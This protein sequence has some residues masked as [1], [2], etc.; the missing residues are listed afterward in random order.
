MLNSYQFL[1]DKKKDSKAFDYENVRIGYQR[2]AAIDNWRRIIACVIE[3]NNFCSD[4]INYIVNSSVSLYFVLALLNSQLFEW[5]FKLTST[6]NHV[7]SSEIDSLPLY[8][9]SFK[10]AKKKRQQLLEQAKSLY[11]EYLQSQNWDKLLEFLNERLPKMP[12]GMP[13]TKNEKSD[14]VHDLLA[15]L[16]EEI[17]RLNKEKQDAIK[18]FLGWLEH[19]VIKGSIEDQKNKTK[20]RNFHESSFE[21][22]EKVLKENKNIP[23]PCPSDTRNIILIEF[24]KAVSIINPLKSTITLTD[25]L[26]DQVVY[27]LYGLTE[28]E[29]KIVEGKSE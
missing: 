20:I 11:H 2:G 4:T 5:R 27:K 6:N 23:D 7:N 8:P 28:D 13:D 9:V 15:F 18:N 16:A 22:L 1:K 26:I 25:N 10:S 17:T 19:E 29:I 21:E 14:V 12:D 24:N 3:P